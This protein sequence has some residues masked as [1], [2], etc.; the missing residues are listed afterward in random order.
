MPSA[1][2]KAWEVFG[3][4]QGVVMMI[5]HPGEVNTFDQRWIEYY[6]WDKY[7]LELFSHI[8]VIKLN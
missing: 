7:P 1:L 3:N 5:V 8:S 6:L 2:A 4:K